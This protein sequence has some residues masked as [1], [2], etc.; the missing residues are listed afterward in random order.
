MKL[1]PSLLAALVLSGSISLSAAAATKPITVLVDQQKLNLTT[2]APIQEGNS[3]LIPMRPIFEKLG[4][5]LVWDAKSNTITA[6]KEGLS[7]KLQ[8]GSKKATIN[9]TVKQLASAPKIIDK[10]TYVPLRF[11]SE[12]T[13]NSVEWKAASRTVAITSKE[14]T[15]DVKGISALFDKYVTYSNTENYD[16]FMNLIDPE[17]P[18]AGI[19]PGIKEQYEIFDAK[20]TVLQMEIIDSKG[21]EAT[22]HTIETSEKVNGPFML[23]S[24]A[25]YVYSLTRKAGGSAWQI[26]GIQIAALQYILPADV[27]EAKVN[28]PKTDEDQI[29]A[30]VQANVDYSN[31][32][33]L[34]GALSTIDETS[35]AYEQSK[36]L[37][38]QMFKAYDLA[39][40][41]D[42]SKIID[43]TG[44]TAAV[45]TV[46]TSKKV[47][48]PEF[49][50]SR[51]VSVN[52]LKKSADGKWKL[53]QTYILTT[54][55]LNQ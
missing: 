18:L 36:E 21:N 8:T 7:I 33:D 16:G 42:S 13:G 4:M 3:V 19:G 28:V 5:K 45:Y 54:T 9:G 26:S 47:K 51:A 52:I 34:D 35:P 55:A 27:L 53:T 1:V 15:A 43:Y 14:N 38:M 24:Q 11:V 40:T 46:Q 49:Q 29:K 44:D 10:V 23:D 20:T 39:I 17:S 2:T 12:A 22:V 41:L 31:K 25:E 32:E 48:G 37:Y 6:T 50:D 30:V